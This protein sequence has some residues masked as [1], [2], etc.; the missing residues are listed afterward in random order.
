MEL[1]LVVDPKRSTVELPDGASKPLG[2][3]ES[4]KAGI[5]LPLMDGPASGNL[6]Y[7][8][9]LN[10]DA[11]RS[12]HR[13]QATGGGFTYTF[14]PVARLNDREA[15]G[16]IS[17][18]VLDAQRQPLANVTVMAQSDEG[19]ERTLVRTVRT[20]PDGV[21]HLD[22]LP[23]DKM[24]YAVAQPR[25]GATL[26]AA[27]AS[28]GF[29][30][31]RL[32]RK[33]T[34]DFAPF[35]PAGSAQGPEGTLQ[36]PSNPD[37]RDEIDLFQDL[38]TGDRKGSFIIQ[39]TQAV[40][41]AGGSRSTYTF[42]SVPAGAYEVRATRITFAGPGSPAVHLTGRKPATL[43]AGEGTRKVDF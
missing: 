15:L 8:L 1:R 36:I 9:I 17:G 19:Q 40:R 42:G 43:V 3:P 11:G 18:R 22:L 24:Y 34:F 25:A 7:D 38:A 39:N 23:M 2:L 21:Y 27:Q 37:Q 12:L 33:Q 5:I 13:T 16:I 32:D 4:L 41:A 28:P 26:Y 31:T 10:L 30:P 14:A 6:L 35:Q 20:G 29:Q